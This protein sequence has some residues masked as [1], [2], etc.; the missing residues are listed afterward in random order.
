MHS[1]PMISFCFPEYHW[2]TYD[3]RKICDINKAIEEGF[4]VEKGI[5]LLKEL[6]SI[7]G[8]TFENVKKENKEATPFIELLIELRK[9]MRS[10][11]YF[12]EADLI[13]DKLKELK[14]QL[15]DT[16]DTTKWKYL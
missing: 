10:K 12:E 6:G 13:R 15:E 14:V 9:T 2:V 3:L 4:N 1:K 16:T 7:L 8:L 11:K 5:N